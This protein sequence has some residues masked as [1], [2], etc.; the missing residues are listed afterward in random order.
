[1]PDHIS[2][3]TVRTRTNAPRKVKGSVALHV[4]DSVLP[5][6]RS[7][8]IQSYKTEWHTHSLVNPSQIH[9]RYYLLSQRL[10]VRGI[11]R[12]LLRTVLRLTFPP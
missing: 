1:M 5:A 7:Q 2:T 6:R 11:D 8:S 3:P 9:P 10:P 4:R 12:H